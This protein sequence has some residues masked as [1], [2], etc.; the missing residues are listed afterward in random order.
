MLSDTKIKELIA[1]KVL[2]NADESH[3]GPVSYDLQVDA[4]YSEDGKID[5]VT[6]M[7]SDSVFVASV[8]SIHLPNNLSARVGLR[9]SRIRQ[10]LTLDAPVYFPG[11][12]TVVYF[13]VTN[14]S[15]EAIRLDTSKGIAQIYFEEVSGEVEKP[16]EGAFSAEFNYRGLANYSAVYADDIKKFK[17]KKSEIEGIESRIYSNV[18]TLFTVFAAIF[19]LFYAT[20]F[21]LRYINPS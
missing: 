11:H 21:S 7:P 6:L 3:L 5:S 19:T 12:N 16:Y 14:V 20:R 1:S 4:F 18:L 9:N 17:E 2:D 15:S 8:E 13:R 10:G